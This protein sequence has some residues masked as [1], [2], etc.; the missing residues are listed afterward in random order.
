MTFMNQERV[1]QLTS[2][3]GVANIPILLGI[4]T[5]ELVTYQTQLSEGPLA[6]K[7]EQLAEICHALKSSAASFG[8]EPL[9]QLAIQIDTK[10][11]QNDLTEDQA[12]IDQVLDLLANTHTTYM[13]YLDALEQ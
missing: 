4:F 7:M 12:L 2:E 8:A 5:G 6:E 3:I 9:C 11:K 1:E 10:S 13:R